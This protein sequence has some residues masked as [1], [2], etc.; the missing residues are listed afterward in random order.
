MKSKLL[1]IVMCSIVLCA[2]SKLPY[3]DIGKEDIGKDEEIILTENNYIYEGELLKFVLNKDIDSLEARIKELKSLTGKDLTLEDELE[4]TN[5]L[6]SELVALNKTVPSFSDILDEVGRRGPTPPL[7]PGPDVTPTELRY[8]LGYNLE[9]IQ[10]QGSNE[11]D[12]VVLESDKGYLSPL[13]GT[14]GYIQIQ[15][16]NM[17]ELIVNENITLSIERKDKNGMNFIYS[18]STIVQ[19]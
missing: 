11:N 6:L 9:S 4:E 12:Q 8:I 1:L 17:N 5:K 14:D 10:I 7:P 2:C 16:V 18:I 15:K 19:K 3:G 13:P